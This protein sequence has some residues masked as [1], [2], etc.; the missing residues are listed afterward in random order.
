MSW[1]ERRFRNIPSKPSGVKE[2]VTP[3]RLTPH[4]TRCFQ[5]GAF[6]MRGLSPSCG[7]LKP[8]T[9]QAASPKGSPLSEATTLTLGYSHAGTS[10]TYFPASQDS[11]LLA[12]WKRRPGQGSAMQDA[13]MLSMSPPQPTSRMARGRFLGA[14]TK[15][16]EGRVWG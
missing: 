8:S 16:E 11:H 13:A 15:P 10:K 6:L 3:L 2:K 5:Q 12:S 4:Q 14:T 1:D 9:R 7:A